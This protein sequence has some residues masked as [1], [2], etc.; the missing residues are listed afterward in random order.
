L[1][2][3]GFCKPDAASLWGGQ[4]GVTCPSRRSGFTRLQRFFRLHL[5]LRNWSEDQ[6]CG[7][8]RGG[9]PGTASSPVLLR[10]G[11]AAGAL[12]FVTAGRDPSWALT[13]GKLREESSA[14]L[15]GYLFPESSWFPRHLTAG[16]R[17]HML[18]AHIPVFLHST[19]SHGGNIL[20]PILGSAWPEPQLHRSNMLKSKT[21][22]PLK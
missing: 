3:C 19:R 18:S 22:M 16:E 21:H 7:A 1:H 12:L 2:S 14:L 4:L 20:L 8:L 5:P 10:C 6:H 17:G 11:F 9:W 13:V 15:G